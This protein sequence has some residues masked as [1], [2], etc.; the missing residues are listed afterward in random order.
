MYAVGALSAEIIFAQAIL[1]EIGLSFLIHARA[2]SST[3]RAVATKQG[4]SRKMKHIHT[5][6]IRS[7]F[8]F[9]ETFHDVISQDRCESKERKHWNARDSTN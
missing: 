2:Q 9:S 8:C 7:R 1:E 5:I 3:V 4:A 6:L